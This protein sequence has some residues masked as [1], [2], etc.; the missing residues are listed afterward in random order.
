MKEIIYT[1][2]TLAKRWDCSER[3]IRNMIDRGELPAFRLGGKLLRIR[4]EDV[5][6][7]ECQN[8]ELPDCEASSLSHSSKT[9]SESDTR[10]EPMTRARLTALRLQSL[11][12]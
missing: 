6:A 7:L 10:S 2:T 9:G 1:P 5:E 11:P 3:H 12:S 8:G 4:G